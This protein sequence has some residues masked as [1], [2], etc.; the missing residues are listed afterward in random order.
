LRIII[1]AQIEALRRI[2]QM[3]IHRHRTFGPFARH[4]LSVDILSNEPYGFGPINK[5]DLAEG[6]VAAARGKGI[7]YAGLPVREWIFGYPGEVI[8]S[9]PYMPEPVIDA[10]KLRDKYEIVVLSCVRV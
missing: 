5:T 2:V 6:Y 3:T 1:N 8:L 4:V 7:V 9:F 10:V